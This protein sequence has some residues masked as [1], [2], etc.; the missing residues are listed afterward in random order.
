M[1]RTIK[2][3]KRKI[4]DGYPAYVIAE[5]GINHNGSLDNAKKLI[6]F[7]KLYGVD[8]VKFQKRTPEICVPLDQQKQMR[9]TPWGYI[10]YLEYRHKVEFGKEEYAEI[11]RTAIRSALIG[12]PLPGT[13][14]R[15]I[16]SSNSTRSVIK[17]LRLPSP[18]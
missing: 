9:E 2:V 12:L 13:N 17:F 8:A 4:G 18:I 6:D 15:R 16:F 7:A 3:G 10:T 1:E 5:I 14:P 11:N